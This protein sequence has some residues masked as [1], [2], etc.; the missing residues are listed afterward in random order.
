MREYF[1]FLKQF[2]FGCKLK[3]VMQ[4]LWNQ[5]RE[6][7]KKNI[8]ETSS[9]SSLNHWFYIFVYKVLVGCLRHEL[10]LL[11]FVFGFYIWTRTIVITVHFTHRQRT[12]EQKKILIY[13]FGF[14]FD[15]RDVINFSSVASDMMLSNHRPHGSNS[16]KNKQRVLNFK[17]FFSTLLKL[18]TNRNILFGMNA[19]KCVQSTS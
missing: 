17:Q 15:I 14:C 9:K 12:E 6:R 2:F 18:A 19:L 11:H 13:F 10:L 8:A 16:F 3:I 1:F 7:E 4:N 5:W